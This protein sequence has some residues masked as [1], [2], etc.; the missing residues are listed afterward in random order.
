M[1]PFWMNNLLSFAVQL[2]VVQVVADMIDKRKF[3]YYMGRL[4][5]FCLDGATEMEEEVNLSLLAFH[6]VGHTVICGERN[7]LFGP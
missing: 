6:N 7:L 5:G 4:Q 1:L 3:I 2:N